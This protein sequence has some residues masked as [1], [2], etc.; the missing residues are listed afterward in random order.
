DRRQ[1][2]AIERF[3][4]RAGFNIVEWFEDGA[5]SGACE[6][7]LTMINCLG[8]HVGMDARV[9]ANV[10]VE[11][12]GVV[13][14]YHR[15]ARRLMVTEAAARELEPRAIA[16]RTAESCYA[17]QIAMGVSDQAAER[18]GTVAAVEAD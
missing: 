1:R 14:F 8:V 10:W 18:F 2:V 11:H 3:A 5:V 4:K 13:R 7:R 9:F 15:T 17:E 12:E 16:V 6:H